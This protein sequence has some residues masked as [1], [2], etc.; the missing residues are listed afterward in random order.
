M[1]A[2]IQNLIR[3]IALV[4]AA[5]AAIVNDLA[6]LS[7]P[8]RWVSMVFGIVGLVGLGLSI[9]IS[10]LAVVGGIWV[11]L[12]RV[13]N[14]VFM[15]QAVIVNYLAPFGVQQRVISG[16]FGVLAAIVLILEFVTAQTVTMRASRPVRAIR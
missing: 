3:I 5:Q 15:A 8:A 16:I 14:G 13:F 12:L 9:F 4:L 11:V 10:A 7:V 6:P 1:T 2:R